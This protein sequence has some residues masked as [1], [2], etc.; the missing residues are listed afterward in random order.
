MSCRDSSEFTGYNQ[1]FLIW[2]KFQN[3]AKNRCFAGPYN[4]PVCQ[5]PSETDNYHPIELG[6]SGRIVEFSEP[7]V[8]AQGVDRFTL[9]S[10][11]HSPGDFFAVGVTEVCYTFAN[12]PGN[13]IDCCFDVTITEGRI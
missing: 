7:S 10:R 11:T 13:R 8:S 12:E 3:I 6:V 9:L 4:T 5:L 1:N 2:R